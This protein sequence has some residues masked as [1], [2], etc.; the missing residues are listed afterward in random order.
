LGAHPEGRDASLITNFSGVVGE[1]DLTFSGT[2]M[3]TK[4]GVK[5]AYSFHTDTRFM[6]GAFIASDEQL[7]RGAFAFI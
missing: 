4:T 3:D 6:L 2:G 7:H 5:A 1:V